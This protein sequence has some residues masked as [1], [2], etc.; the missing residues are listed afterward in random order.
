MAVPVQLI[1]LSS[2]KWRTVFFVPQC[3]NINI[4]LQDKQTAGETAMQTFTFN[5]SNQPIRVEMIDN[6][7]WF[8]AKDVCDALQL[9]EVSNTISR[10]DDD[11]KLT[12]TLFVSGQGRQMWLV[13]ESG[14]YNLIFQ[15]RKSEAKAFRK[16]VTAEVLPTIRK[17]G[18]YEMR[19]PKEG[20][21]QKRRARRG[22][23]INAEVLNLLW[24]IGE[25]LERGDQKQVALELGVT[26]S[27]VN[28]T[29]NGYQ[30]S[31]RILKAL[32]RKA[33]ERREEFMLYNCPAVMADRL[34]SGERTRINNPLPP[35][36]IEGKRGLLGNQNARKQKEGG[37][38]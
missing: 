33:L 35:V 20:C 16:W 29:L 36:H 7:P 12:R 3:L 1:D 37:A 28:N 13:N 2:G 21:A 26:V 23:L 5:P 30:R 17:T 10:L 24:L 4:M 34:L 31:P 14:L 32:Y 25:S 27:A 15:S 8:V 18:R 38:L 19:K 6:E 22:E 9:T 11:E